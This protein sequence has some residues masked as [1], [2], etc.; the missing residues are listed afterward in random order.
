MNFNLICNVKKKAHPLTLNVKAQGYSMNV[1][2]KCKDKT[3]TITLLTPN[4]TTTL[5]FYEVKTREGLTLSVSTLAGKSSTSEL[6]LNLCFKCR[7]DQE[8]RNMPGA[9]PPPECVWF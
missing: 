4:Q 8:N 2:V 1:E 6:S 7:G 3:G 5:N 9:A